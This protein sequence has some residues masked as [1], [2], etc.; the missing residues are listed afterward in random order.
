MNEPSGH[1]HSDAHDSHEEHA[2]AAG[3][4]HHQEFNWFHGFIG[5]REGVEPS[6]LW[7]PEGMPA[8]FGATLLN[9]LLLVVLFVK[10]GGPK[11]TQGLQQ[12]RR[13]LL[14]GMDEAEAMR[15]QSAERLATYRT[16][17][18]NLDAEVQRVRREMREAAEAERQRVLEEAKVR[19]VRLEE[20]ARVLV[21]QELDA[22]REELVLTTSRAAL[23]SARTLLSAA[24][25]SED[26]QRLM[27]E[28]LDGLGRNARSRERPS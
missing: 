3:E 25:T 4:H 15:K 22:M 7:R 20:E 21:D 11:L 2:A 12:R 16:K 5:A 6:L 28:Y 8:P 9:T 23:R 24:T 13:R 27:N 18:D 1:S 14:K 10:L 17:L 26:Q 19:R